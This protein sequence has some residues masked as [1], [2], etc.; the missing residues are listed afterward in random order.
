MFCTRCG[1]NNLDTDQ[2][3]RSCSAPLTKPGGA[4]GAS[5]GSPQQPYPY[6]TPGQGQQQPQQQQPQSYS[7]YPGYQGYP[8]PQQ[9]Y[10]NQTYPQQGASGRA[11][12][13]LVLSLVSIFMCG[14]LTSIPGMILGKMEMNAIRQ[15]QAPSSG[16]GIAKAG[17]YIGLVVTILYGLII[18][19][20]IFL[21]ALGLAA[22]SIQ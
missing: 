10:A 6:S 8:P 13:S 7:P 11:I 3:C 17:F 20:Y 22:A 9:G 19:G 16:D 18:L 15:G 5:S 14:F 2:F 21:I 12:T 4:S 1:A